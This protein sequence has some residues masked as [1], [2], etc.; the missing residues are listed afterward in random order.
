MIFSAIGQSVLGVAMTSEIV[1]EA[2]IKER[3]E[4]VGVLSAIAASAN[5]LAPIGSGFMFQYRHNL[6]YVAASLLSLLTLAIFYKTKI[7]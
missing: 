1:G 2:D 4:A 5:I 6:P 3:G 7:K